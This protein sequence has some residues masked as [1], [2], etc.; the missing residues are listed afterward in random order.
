MICSSLLELTCL[1]CFSKH[2]KNVK[3]VVYKGFPHGFLNFDVPQGMKEAKE[4]VIDGAA[5]LLELF[6]L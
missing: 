4:T 2:Q 1:L 5:A 3:L 6:E